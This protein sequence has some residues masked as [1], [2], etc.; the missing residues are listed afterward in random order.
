MRST[1]RRIA[2]LIPVTLVVTY[3]AIAISTASANKEKPV[4]PIDLLTLNDLSSLKVSPNGKMLFVFEREAQLEANNYR[5]TNRILSLE[6]GDVLAEWD[7]GEVIFQY[8]ANVPNS[9]LSD[10]MPTWSP[11]SEWIFYLSR[12][13]GRTTVWRRAVGHER[14][15]QVTSGGDDVALFRLS[16]DGKIL[17]TEHFDFATGEKKQEEEAL[18]GFLF[19]DRFAPFLSNRPS[20]STTQRTDGLGPVFVHNLET[21]ESRAATTADFEA[22]KAIRSGYTRFNRSSQLAEDYPHVQH[23][24]IAPN[25]AAMAWTEPLDTELRGIRAPRTLISQS[26]PSGQR[27]IC[28]KPACTGSLH[29]LWW[30]DAGDEV[31]FYRREDLGVGAFYGWSPS[32]GSVRTIY[33]GEKI[34]NTVLHTCEKRSDNLICLEEAPLQPARVVN[35]D[36]ELGNVEVLY[37]P[38]TDFTH[39]D[40]APA[41]VVKVRTDF[42]GI[43]SYGWLMKPLNHRKG[44]RYPL[45]ITTYRPGPFLRGNVGDEFPAQVF[46]A[47][48]FVVLSMNVP[49]DRSFLQKENLAIIASQ[50]SRQNARDKRIKLSGLEN[51]IDDL[52]RMGLIDAA[53]VGIAGLSYGA[54]TTHYAV[55]KSDRFA[56]AIAGGPSFESTLYF[57]G[58]SGHRRFLA[59]AGLGSPIQE[60]KGAEF[61][62]KNIAL[63]L[64]AEKVSTPLLI[65]AADNEYM[66][67]LQTVR[68]L[69]D[70]NKPVEMYV[71][72]D[73]FHGKWQPAHR[74]NIYR[75]NLQWFQFWLQDKEVSDPVGP[76]Q[77]VRWR[78]MRD[79]FCADLK[80][81][82]KEDLPAYCR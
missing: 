54:E 76:D 63:P 72:P 57:L 69:K 44:E 71:F 40:L 33:R 70:I 51:A 56:A 74:Y 9:I 6:N 81:E 27:I 43:D 13:D 64:N 38:N 50:K 62:W 75:R 18:R 45:I 80:A 68:A 78:K 55:W 15:E 10:V 4:E 22:Y 53:R 1:P 19:D 2:T 29:A 17:Y 48:G 73:E 8:F 65:H 20:F 12:R 79:G 25:N 28:D 16:E 39:L 42:A 34:Y 35:F 58:N 7:A 67:A 47:N 49:E 41:E 5:Q 32:S 24:T 36:I 60:D 61:G 46:A 30:N 14:T 59:T 23:T 77:Y 66:L 11:D 26:S 21:Q 31:I 37:D 3:A 52:D 82:E